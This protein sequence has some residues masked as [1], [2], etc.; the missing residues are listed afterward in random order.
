MVVYETSDYEDNGIVAVRVNKTTTMLPVSIQ[1]LLLLC[2]VD[3]DARVDFHKIGA[4]Y[5]YP[6]QRQGAIRC[7]SSKDQQIPYCLG[8]GPG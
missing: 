3:T 7:P 8:L 4:T 6:V 2:K 1:L 5:R